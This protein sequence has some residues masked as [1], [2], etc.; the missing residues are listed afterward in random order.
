MLPLIIVKNHASQDH[1]CDPKPEVWSSLSVG[2]APGCNRS[3]FFFFVLV[4]FDR[5]QIQI[6]NAIQNKELTNKKND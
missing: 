1:I 4:I 2:L 6:I 5:D 3:R